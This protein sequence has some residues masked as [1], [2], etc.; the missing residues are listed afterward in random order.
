MKDYIDREV[1]RWRIA[2]FRVAILL[3]T[4]MVGLTG[5]VACSRQKE[6]KAVE[7]KPVAET[8]VVKASPIVASNVTG[9]VQT[10]RMGKPRDSHF[11]PTRPQTSTPESRKAVRDRQWEFKKKTIAQQIQKQEKAIEDVSSQIKTIQ[12]DAQGTN[13]AALKELERR[14][15]DL[16]TQNKNLLDTQAGMAQHEAQ[17]NTVTRPDMAE[18]IARAIREQ[19]EKIDAVSSQMQTIE[20]QGRNANPTV[21]AAFNSL[22]EKRRSYDEERGK[23]AG[24]DELRQKREAAKAQLVQLKSQAGDGAQPAD[25]G[26]D[27]AIDAA[28]QEITSLAKKMY[29]VEM[30]NRAS[31][32][33]LSQALE[34]VRTA[35]ADYAASLMALPG[36][37]DLQ[38]KYQELMKYYEDLVIAQ[39]RMAQGEKI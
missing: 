22:A 25:S 28:R 5:V 29:E 27:K 9:T 19:L 37:R 8:T 18:V 34:S 36:Y 11:T 26:L 2:A 23:L 12:A 32:P 1:R 17:P 38:A 21:A 15:Q 7:K 31:A 30:A 24:M 3:L 16:L 4:G 13:Q 10:V 20:A 35:E 14:L 33:A 39:T 6:P